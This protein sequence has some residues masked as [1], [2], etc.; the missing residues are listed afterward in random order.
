MAEVIKTTIHKYNI[1]NDNKTKDINDFLKD[2][3]KSV[4]EYTKYIYSNEIKYKKKVANKE[5]KIKE[6]Q[7]FTFNLSNNQLDAPSVLDHKIIDIHTRL[8]A[9]SLSSAITQS[10][11][12]IKGI[13]EHRIQLE[14]KIEYLKEKGWSKTYTEKLY[15]QQLTAKEPELKTINAELS[16]KNASFLSN[17]NNKFIN[18]WIKMYCLG[19]Y[20]KDRGCKSILIPIRFTKYIK[21]LIEEGYE[22]MGSFLICKDHVEIRWKKKAELKTEGSIVGCDTG[23]LDVV[24]FSEDDILDRSLFQDDSLFDEYNQSLKVIVRKRRGSNAYKRA[25][26]NRNNILKCMIN[27]CNFDGVKQLNVENNS[28]LKYGKK[29]SRYL[30]C[31]VF[32]EIKEKLKNVCKEIGVRIIFTSPTY[33][34]QRCSNA[35]CGWTQKSNRKDKVFTCKVC[36]FKIDSD[37]NS[38]RNQIIILPYVP[39]DMRNL[40]LNLKGFFWKPDGFYDKDGKEFRVPC[41]R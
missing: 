12:I 13:A 29:S 39:R 7:E 40:R 10:C 33:K 38:G 34:S 20:R 14:N 36:K 9:R 31:H 19:D 30:G 25:L 27:R 5:T 16:S 3:E 18:G 6:I 35:E 21:D 41:L 2:Y 22:M 26:I 24:S 32:G 11:G 8:S 4:I 1:C 17:N 15:Q 37:K 23:I 28:T